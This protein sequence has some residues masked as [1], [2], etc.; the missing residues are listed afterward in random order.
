MPLMLCSRKRLRRRG[1]DAQELACKGT[2][3]QGCGGQLGRGILLRPCWALSPFF[4][5]FVFLL[6]IKVS[7]IIQSY[8]GFKC[9]FFVLVSKPLPTSPG[10][11]WVSAV[12][13]APSLSLWAQ[14]FFLVTVSWML[15]FPLG[16]TLCLTKFW[17][18]KKRS[19]TYWHLIIFLHVQFNV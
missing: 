15:R 3:I 5:L 17:G 2:G 9:W 12:L 1:E 7:L 19:V 8:V 16:L 14:G 6:F 4:F 10:A 13:S 18:A 11:R